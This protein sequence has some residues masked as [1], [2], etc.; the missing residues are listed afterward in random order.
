[1]SKSHV[2]LV[3]IVI[4]VCLFGVAGLYYPGGTTESANTVGY[5]WAHNF[6]SS[7]FAP[8]ALNGAPNPARLVAIPAM[9]ILCVGLAALFWSISRK[10]T[11]RVHKKAIEIGGVGSMVYA[12]LV[13]TP[14]HDL[15]IDI[16][17][18]FG[19]VA[20]LAILHLLHTARRSLLFR[21][22]TVP[23]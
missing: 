23:P 18:P 19:L 17:L 14:M 12:S 13:V 10:A 11:S 9:L 4:S 8:N 7:L 16:A 21:L 6:I 22:G 2:P 20:L 3:A 15:M 1:M 5:N